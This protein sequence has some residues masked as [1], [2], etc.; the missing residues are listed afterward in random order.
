MN[1]DLDQCQYTCMTLLRN[2][3]ENEEATVMMAD[4]AFRKNDYESAM[5]HFQQVNLIEHHFIILEIKLFVSTKFWVHS[6]VLASA[7]APRLFCSSGQAC[8][9]NEEN[10]K[11]SE[12]S[13]ISVKIGGICW[14]KSNVRTWTQFLPR[15]IRMVNYAGSSFLYFESNCNFYK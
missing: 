7:K 9:G 11:S 3:K 6:F 13:W 2:D 5:F 8:G 10:R 15:I 4:L 1:D 14:Y 12:C